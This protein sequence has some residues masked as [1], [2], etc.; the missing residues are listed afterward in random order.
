MS[1]HVFVTPTACTNFTSQV[2]GLFLRDLQDTA[3][4]VSL[5]PVASLLRQPD[6]SPLGI[7]DYGPFGL[8]YRRRGGER[9]QDMYS[10]VLVCISVLLV[11]RIAYKPHLTCVL[12]SFGICY[13]CG[14][15]V[16]RHA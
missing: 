15:C 5:L 7:I 13:A 6:A 3:F 4:I 1:L 10:P 11:H 8:E 16:E 2:G 14:S 9:Y 12:R